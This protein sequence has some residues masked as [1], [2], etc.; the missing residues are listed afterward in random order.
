MSANGWLSTGAILAGLAVGSGAFAAHFLDGYFPKKYAG[1]ER[2]VAGATV[3]ASTKYLAD[4]KTAAEYQMY[5]ALAL[6]V[7]GL[8]ASSRP[9][10]LLTGAGWSFLLG[11]LLFSGSLYVLTLTGERR[12]GM[13]TPIGG[14][15]FLL[16]WLLLAIACCP[17]CARQ[18]VSSPQQ[19]TGPP[20]SVADQP[21]RN[22]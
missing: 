3:P 12:L 9:S 18:T 15:F 7:V 10:G 8:L 4:F 19:L 11:I 21:P 6:L 16:G 13:I 20:G 17:C 14:L 5:H 2:V 1:Q 22:V